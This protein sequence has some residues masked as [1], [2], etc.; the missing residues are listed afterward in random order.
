MSSGN[1]DLHTHTTVSDGTIGIARRVEFAAERGLDAIAITDHDVVADE[2]NAPVDQRGE[3]TLITGVEVRADL[4]DTKI[5]VL[6][7]FVDPAN[8]DLRSMLQRARKFRR[9][10]NRDL[11]SNLGEVTEL[12][13]TYEEL[14]GSVDGNLGRPHLAAYLKEE[15][16]VDS[17]GEAFEKY[18]GED[19]SAYVAMRR[20]PA[21]EVV[22]TIQKAGGLA[23][24][25][26]P[27]RIRTDAETVAQMVERLAEMGMDGIEAW[28]PYGDG[29]D[30]TY[31]AVGVDDAL[32]L[33]ELHD[34]LMT[35]GSDCHGPDSGKF[36]MGEVRV[37]EA[38]FRRLVD[39]AGHGAHVES[40]DGA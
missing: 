1:T 8:E 12:N 31:A 24:L 13:P 33:A 34:L 26:H 38:S 29:R 18:L 2:L 11:V 23:S 21:R 32:N 4:F 39:A 20:L 3:I 16:V 17:I 7:Y 37:P 9:Q 14:A 36:R 19:G 25:A 5:E 6:G 27:G 22:E 28:Y 30:P 40:G 35:G 15:D 10:R